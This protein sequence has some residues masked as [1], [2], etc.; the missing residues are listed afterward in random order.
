MK[1]GDVRKERVEGVGEEGVR[2]KGERK[3]GRML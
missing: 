2:R 1:E 3:R